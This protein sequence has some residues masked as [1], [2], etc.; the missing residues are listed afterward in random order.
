MGRHRLG[1]NPWSRTK[2]M[3]PWLLLAVGGGLLAIPALLGNHS[4]Q[5]LTEQPILGSAPKLD[6]FVVAGAFLVISGLLS[7]LPRFLKNWQGQRNGAAIQL[8]D[9]RRLGAKQSLILTKVG[10]RVL[11]V[12]A[13]D[14]GLST[15]SEFSQEE[16]LAVLKSVEAAKPSSFQHVLTQVERGYAR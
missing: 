11:L 9:V 6:P 5:A 16:S 1:L 4:A 2:T 12:G 3:L 15:L 8:L 13:T 7:F 14:Q 10:D